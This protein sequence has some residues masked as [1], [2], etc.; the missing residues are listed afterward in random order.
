[1][2]NNSLLKLHCF[3][4]TYRL[5]NEVQLKPLNLNEIDPAY[6]HLLPEALHF[7]QYLQAYLS[8][9]FVT[10]ELS[11]E[12]IYYGQKLQFQIII[13]EDEKLEKLIEKMQI[14]NN[15][16]REESFNIIV[17]KFASNCL[18]KIN[19]ETDDLR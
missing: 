11:I 17:Y 13:N 2:S 16:T 12:V 1:M 4:E 7:P 10:K 15:E 18:F 6:A 19:W 5:L 3:G 8:G 9:A 14:K